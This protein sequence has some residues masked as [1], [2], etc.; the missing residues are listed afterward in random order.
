MRSLSLML[1]VPSMSQK[2]DPVPSPLRP[3]ANQ[4]MKGRG[5][6]SVYPAAIADSLPARCGAWTIAKVLDVWKSGARRALSLF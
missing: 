6:S 2:A 4:S 1:R 5:N 3:T